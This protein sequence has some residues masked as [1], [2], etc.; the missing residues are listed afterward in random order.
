MRRVPSPAPPANLNGLL[1]RWVKGF[2]IRAA[3]AELGG[4]RSVLDLGCGLCEIVPSVG[5][6]VAYEG[7]ERD[8][9][10]YERA[11]RLHPGRDFS[12]ADLE[13]GPFEPKRRVERI[14]MLAV[15]EHLR[16]PEA[17]LARARQWVE[18]GGRLVATTPAPSAHAL[19][20]LGARLRLLSR[21]ADEQHER[22]WG[23]AEI[24]GAAERTGW[25]MV[26]SRR[27]LFGANQLIVLEAEDR[28]D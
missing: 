6:D 4:A 3:L 28:R 20:D 25:R 23:I 14:L 16:D 15:W 2:R 18:P 10:M 26:K 9:W 19:L 11:W 21:N 13:S 8:R 7:V 17:L 27:F 1:S 5:E 22:L 12:S 24:A